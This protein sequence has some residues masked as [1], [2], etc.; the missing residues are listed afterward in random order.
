MACWH[1]GRS[2]HDGNQARTCCSLS[3]HL[4]QS[5][6]LPR[7]RVRWI[8]FVV[9]G[10]G[11]KT[12]STE[13]RPT[14]RHERQ[15]LKKIARVMNWYFSPPGIGSWLKGSCCPCCMLQSEPC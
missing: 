4:F 14:V 7:S 9:L 10:S 2:S 11:R 1:M 3:R 8:T 15:F 12:D 5:T 13:L 6:E